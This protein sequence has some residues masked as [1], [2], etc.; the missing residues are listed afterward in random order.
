M[1]LLFGL[2]SLATAMVETFATNRPVGL[3]QLG[4]RV[5]SK[6]LSKHPLGRDAHGGRGIRYR[7]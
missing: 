2:A 3:R 4:L 7:D 1:L 5:S 6:G